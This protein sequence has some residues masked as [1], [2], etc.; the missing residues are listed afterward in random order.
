MLEIHLFL[1]YNIEKLKKLYYLKGVK[2]MKKLVSI[3]KNIDTEMYDV[4]VTN[5]SSSVIYET[6]CSCNSFENAEWIVDL[7]KKD[8]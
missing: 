4:V 6:I 8:K 5:S 1:C 2:Y 7:I 3:I